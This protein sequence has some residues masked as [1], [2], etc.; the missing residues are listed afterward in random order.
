[1][2]T[3]RE[4]LQSIVKIASESS[5]FSRRTQAIL[6][7]ALLALGYTEGQRAIHFVRCLQRSE[8]FKEIRKNRGHKEATKWIAEATLEDTGEERVR[9]KQPIAESYV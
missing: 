3:M 9:V 1:M 7:E 8:Q 5:E 4:S 6:N 2:K